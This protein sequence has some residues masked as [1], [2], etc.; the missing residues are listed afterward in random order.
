M[1]RWPCSADRSAI[2]LVSALCAGVTPLAAQQTT[3]LAPAARASTTPASTP[4][5]PLLGPRVQPEYRS[6]QPSVADSSVSGRASSM[7]GGRHTI[8]LST[9][10]LVLIVIIIVLLIAR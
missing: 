9:L 8:V 5:A 10:S 2:I 6:F 4:S 1:L 3:S 7:A